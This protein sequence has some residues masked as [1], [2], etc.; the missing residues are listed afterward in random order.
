MG[1]GSFQ[2]NL[3]A[4]VGNTPNYTVYV[5]NSN[6]L[7]TSN[8]AC[9]TTGLMLSLQPDKSYTLRLIAIGSEY[10]PSNISTKTIPQGIYTACY[11]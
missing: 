7:T 11:Y 10:L 2:L 3:T 4:P 6:G 8:D 5:T 1:I 9:S